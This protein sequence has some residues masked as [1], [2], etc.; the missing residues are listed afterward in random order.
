MVSQI[1]VCKYMNY[2]LGT[3]PLKFSHLEKKSADTDGAI[4]W[5]IDLNIDA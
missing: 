2:L 3:P 4:S 1:I 5:Q